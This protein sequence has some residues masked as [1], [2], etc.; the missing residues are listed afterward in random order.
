MIL[1]GLCAKNNCLYS[2][3]HTSTTRLLFCRLIISGFSSPNEYVEILYKWPT[4]E[5]GRI[6]NAPPHSHTFNMHT[7]WKLTTWNCFSNCMTH[8]ECQFNVFRSPEIIKML[9]EWKYNPSCYVC[10]IWVWKLYKT[11]TKYSFLRHMSQFRKRIRDR[12][13]NRS[14]RATASG[15]GLFYRFWCVR[16]LWPAHP[17]CWKKARF[18]FKAHNSSLILFKPV[19]CEMPAETDERYFWRSRVAHVWRHNRIDVW[20]NHNW[21]IAGDSG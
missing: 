12:W 16:V 19:K 10:R 5:Q 9:N 14:P 20:H 13:K 1:P 3:I 11:L 15:R 21:S 6:S 4:R 8:S 17:S 7:K 2:S 18:V